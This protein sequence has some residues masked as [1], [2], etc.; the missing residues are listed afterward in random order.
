MPDEKKTGM[1]YLICF[2]L[3]LIIVS[4]AGASPDLKHYPNL[5]KTIL[6][7]EDN[8]EQ[9]DIIFWD[10]L[11][12][13]WFYYEKTDSDNDT[14]KDRDDKDLIINWKAFKELTA[15]E[16]NEAINELKDYAVSNPTKINIQNYMVAQKIATKKAHTFMTVWMD[17]LRDHPLLDETVKRPASS[18]VSFNLANAKSRAT[19]MIINE[20]AQD[21]D[22]GLVIFYTQDNYYSSIQMPIIKRLLEK[23]GWQPSRF[24]SVQENPDAAQ[25]FGIETIPEIWLAAKDGRKARVTAGARTADVIKENIVAAYERMTGNQLIK[26]PF[27]FQD[28][29]LYQQIETR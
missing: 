3:S 12:R 6:N 16:T 24:I 5:S 25:K 13:G 14:Q 27:Q 10:D 4:S 17:V 8:R 22:M 29:E 26:D 23:T 1:K 2:A 15:K 9:E 7:T 20:L 18:F 11:K 21:P 19:D 28:T